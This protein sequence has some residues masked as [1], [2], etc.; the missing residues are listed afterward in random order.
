[1]INPDGVRKDLMVTDI[2]TCPFCQ[3]HLFLDQLKTN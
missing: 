2:R 1:V 3:R